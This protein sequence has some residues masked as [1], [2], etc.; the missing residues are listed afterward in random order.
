MDKKVL[1]TNTYKSRYFTMTLKDERKDEVRSVKIK[2]S[3]KTMAF[4]YL[5]HYIYIAR[6]WEPNAKSMADIML[7]DSIE[8]LENKAKSFNFTITDFKEISKECFESANGVNVKEKVDNDFGYDYE[9][10]VRIN[11]AVNWYKDTHSKDD[12]DDDCDCDDCDCDDCCE[13]CGCCGYCDCDDDDDDDDDYDEDE[14]VGDIFVELPKKNNLSRKE[15]VAISERFA[16]NIAKMLEAS[17][18]VEGEAKDAIID[19]AH[20]LIDEIVNINQ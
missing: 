6:K 9:I 13:C 10:H 8:V 1:I 3:S 12:S 11:E 17:R 16:Q 5:L 2:T 15:Q 20:M 19:S 4:R 18:H 7:K 14:D